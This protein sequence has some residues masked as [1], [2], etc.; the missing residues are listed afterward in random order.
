MITRVSWSIDAC[1]RLNDDTD[2]FVAISSPPKDT[3]LPQSYTQV[4]GRMYVNPHII[5]DTLNPQPISHYYIFS[6]QFLF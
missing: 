3:R 6:K 5:P 1:Y 4:S 2:A